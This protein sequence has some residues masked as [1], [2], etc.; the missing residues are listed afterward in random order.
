MDYYREVFDIFIK[1]KGK[2]KHLKSDTYKKFDKCT[3]IKLTIENPDII[4]KD[5]D[6]MRTILNTLRKLIVTTIDVF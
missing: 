5:K 3:H 1:P 6:F 4:R 2:N